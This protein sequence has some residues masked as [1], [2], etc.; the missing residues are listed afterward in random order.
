MTK[1]IVISGYYGFGNFGDEAILAVLLEHLKQFDVEAVVLSK[2]PRKTSMEYMVNA[3]NS[4]DFQQVAELIKQSDILISGGGSLLQD[5]TSLKSLLYYLWILSLALWHKK[6]VIIFAQGIGPI[7][8]KFAQLLTSLVLK[9]CTY[10]SVRDFKSQKLLEWMGVSSQLLCDPI[11]SLSFPIEKKCGTVGIQL[12]DFSTLN[13]NLLNKLAH[14]VAKDFQDKKIE[15]FALQYEMDFHVCEKFK[16]MLYTIAPN[17]EVEIVHSLC[18]PEMLERILDV[19]YMIAMRFHALVVAVKA[20][21]PSVAINYDT[22]VEKLA[23]EAKIP[24]ISMNASEDFDQVFDNLKNI[25]DLNLIE[26]SNSLKF[27]WSGIDQIISN[28]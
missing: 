8:N 6:Q 25:H 5:V 11:F 4:F 28:I 1:K 14:Q 23:Q 13:D 15:L 24:V 7:R 9:K 21:I 17:I 3:L 26:Y 2:N 18:L 19:E 20:G 27:D 22:K 10:V 16:K 12:R